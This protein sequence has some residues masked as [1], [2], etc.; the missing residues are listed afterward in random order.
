MK[1]NQ[2][3]AF[4]PRSILLLSAQTIL[5]IS[6]SSHHNKGEWNNTHRH[7][8][9]S[10]GFLFHSYTHLFFFDAIEASAV[11]APPTLPNVYYNQL[12]WN[13]NHLILHPMY[14]ESDRSDPRLR[15]ACIITFRSKNRTALT[16][17]EGTSCKGDPS[18]NALTADSTVNKPPPDMAGA[19]SKT[20]SGRVL[21][22][23]RDA[24]DVLPY[25]ILIRM[26]NEP[27]VLYL[28]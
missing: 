25:S 4:P 8:A 15:L 16:A 11:L 18:V 10:N 3:M 20:Q 7:F 21:L 12:E 14:T 1:T 23:P 19:D 22:E 28:N 17:A 24:A 26:E 9:I 13:T 5:P 2:I 27:H 6:S